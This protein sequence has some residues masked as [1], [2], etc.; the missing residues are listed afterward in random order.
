[1]GAVFRTNNVNKKIEANFSKKV[2]LEV[3]PKCWSGVLVLAQSVR[4]GQ[5]SGVLGRLV[6]PGY[7]PKKVCRDL[8]GVTWGQT[9]WR[10]CGALAERS[11]HK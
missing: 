9:F 1:M 2:F 4:A 6:W 10:W 5:W 8:G 7:L 3:A 11:E